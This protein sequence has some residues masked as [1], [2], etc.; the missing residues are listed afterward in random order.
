[1]N[2]NAIFLPQQK[3]YIFASLKCD[4]IQILVH[5]VNI[6]CVYTYRTIYCI[7]QIRQDLYRCGKATQPHIF[8][9]KQ[10]RRTS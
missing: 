7:S 9:P 6:S 8:I 10:K 1:M 2:F 5:E 4:M 3:R